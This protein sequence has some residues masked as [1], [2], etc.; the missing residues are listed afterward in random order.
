MTRTIL[1]VDMD[2]FFASVEVRRRPELRGKPVV[3]GGI[4]PRGVVAAASYEARSYG[5][6]SAQPAERARRLCP[7]ATFI[8]G[9]HAYYAEV[10]ARI[11]DLL[12]TFTPLVEPLS[13]DEAFLDVTG[14]RRLHGDGPAIAAVIRRAVAETEGLGCAVGVAPRKFLAKLASKAAKPRPGPIGRGPAAGPGI[15]VVEAGEELAFLHPLPVEA[16]WGVGPATL[17]KITPLG[18]KTVG[19]LAAVPEATLRARLGEAAGRQLHRLSH[20]FDDRPVEPNVAPKSLGHE[21][22]FPT[23]HTDRAALDTELVRLVDATAARLRARGVRGRTVTIKVRFSDFHTVTRSSTLPEAICSA[24]A[25]LDAARQLLAEVDVAGGVR[26]LG[27]SLARFEDAGPKQLS[28][29]DESRVAWDDVEA[30][31][32]DIRARYGAG[33]IA[34]AVLAGR[35]GIRVHRPGAQQWGPGEAAPSGAPTPPS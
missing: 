12:R 33:A 35:R 17:R 11:M 22:T 20:G 6:H 30:A 23:D 4:G 8:Q 32:D 5:V 28:L 2:A 3:V 31:V 13:L 26:L 14:A 24:H 34:P 25:L 18:V 9:D 27:V 7:E 15:V 21:E 1:H 16:L 29:G 19:D 10:S